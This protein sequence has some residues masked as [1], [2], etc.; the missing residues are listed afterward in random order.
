[1]TT[2]KFSCTIVKEELRMKK[3]TRTSPLFTLFSRKKQTK[4][5][6]FSLI[7]LLVVVGIIGLLLI[8]GFQQFGLQMAKGRDARRKADLDK[9]KKIYEDYAGDYNQ[10]P[11]FGTLDNCGDSTGTALEKY[12]NEIPCDPADGS[13]YVYAPY[14]DFGD[15]S[16]GYRVY[17]K[18]ELDEDPDIATLGCDQGIGCGIPVTLISTGAEEYNYGVSEGVPVYYTGDGG[19]EVPTEGICCP[20]V[21]TSCNQTTL[22]G[23]AC[24]GSPPY[25]PYPDLAACIANSP[26]TN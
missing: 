6:G 25:A 1:M 14:P 9:I 24:P 19:G 15:T 18:L 11:P 10:Y 12:L 5:K 21:N 4:K 26:C 20:L 17:S 16:G 3:T 7:E 22:V 23:G 8:I 2:L 13:P